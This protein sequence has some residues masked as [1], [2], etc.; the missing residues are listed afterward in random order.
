MNNS[1]N[2]HI[3]SEC[4]VDIDTLSLHEHVVLHSELEANIRENHLND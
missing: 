2:N 3:C 1:A 4:G